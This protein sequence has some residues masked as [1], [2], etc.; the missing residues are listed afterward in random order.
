MLITT[1]IYFHHQSV[2]EIV[3]LNGP[4]SLQLIDLSGLYCARYCSWYCI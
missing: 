1:V 4:L 3:T 2:K